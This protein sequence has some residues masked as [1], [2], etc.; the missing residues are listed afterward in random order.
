MSRIQINSKPPDFRLAS[1][2]DEMVQL[3]DFQGKKN[4]ILVFN[5]GFM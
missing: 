2:Q 5:R 1:T 3:S 4:V